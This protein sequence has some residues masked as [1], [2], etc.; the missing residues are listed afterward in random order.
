[1]AKLTKA[2]ST[3]YRAANFAVKRY[4]GQLKAHDALHVLKIESL[5]SQVV[6]A[7]ALQ[8]IGLAIADLEVC[9]LVKVGRYDSL[10][11][12]LLLA[13]MSLLR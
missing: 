4:L 10:L 8:H 13:G 7:R 5:P 6:D 1:M 12:F 3:E 11:L 2:L 9:L